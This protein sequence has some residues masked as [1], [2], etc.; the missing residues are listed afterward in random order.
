MR[1]QKR[2]E[3]DV[4]L[5]LNNGQWFMGLRRHRK[6]NGVLYSEMCEKIE[7]CEIKEF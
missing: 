7:S 3:D 4:E 1:R 5:E 2:R 6:K